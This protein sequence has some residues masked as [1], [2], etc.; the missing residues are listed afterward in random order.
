[1][2]SFST[3]ARKRGFEVVITPGLTLASVEG[4]SCTKSADEA[5]YESYLRC[6]IAGAAATYADVLEIQAQ[7][8]QSGP[9]EYREFVSAA[10]KQARAANPDVK[11][12][13]GFRVRDVE[14][15]DDVAS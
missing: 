12:I 3:L 14:N 9:E 6:N 5:E 8:R 15:I 7:T 2:R 1:M 10:A 11:V 13:S 4:A